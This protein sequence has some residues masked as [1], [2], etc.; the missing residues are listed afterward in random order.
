MAIFYFQ[1]SGTFSNGGDI[2]N[3]PSFIEVPAGVSS[4]GLDIILISDNIEEEKYLH[5]LFYK[6]Y[7]ACKQKGK[8]AENL[9]AFS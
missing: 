9:K 2:I 4:V 1:I 3:I 6:Y 8:N 5:L 7:I